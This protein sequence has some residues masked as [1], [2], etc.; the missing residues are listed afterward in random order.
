MKISPDSKQVTLFLSAKLT[1][2]YTLPY[3]PLP[4]INSF[5]YMVTGDPG[6][7]SSSSRSQEN[8]HSSPSKKKKGLL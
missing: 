3:P 6:D 4:N 1:A 8:V 2:E 5:L 7:I